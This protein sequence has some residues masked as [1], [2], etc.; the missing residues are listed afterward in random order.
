MKSDD[1]MTSNWSKVISKK[2]VRLKI[3]A[4]FLLWHFVTDTVADKYNEFWF[5]LKELN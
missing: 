4:F 3:L 2:L 5:H 1:V